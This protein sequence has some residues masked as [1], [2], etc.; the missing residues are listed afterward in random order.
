[1][2]SMFGIGVL[3]V[4]L[5]SL[6][7]ARMMLSI[8]PIVMVGLTFAY[9]MFLSTTETQLGKYSFN[10]AVRYGLPFFV[11]IYSSAYFLSWG[12]GVFPYFSGE[13]LAV[14]FDPSFIRFFAA[15]LLGFH[16]LILGNLL[17]VFYVER[18]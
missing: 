11:A 12:Y 18:R 13:G 3:P 2:L 7:M 17:Y 1:M 16:V 14:N 9:L 10:P 8:F 5:A 4:S 6:G 15:L